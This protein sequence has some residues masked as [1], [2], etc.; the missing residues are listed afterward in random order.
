MAESYSPRQKDWRQALHGIL[1]ALGRRAGNGG[2][3]EDE[4]CTTMATE[5]KIPKDVTHD[6]LDFLVRDELISRER[7]EG[8]IVVGHEYNLLP[9][10][11]VLLAG[12]GDHKYIKFTNGFLSNVSNVRSTGGR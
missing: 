5:L 4:L 3:L 8:L 10:G 12:G 7:V 6:A 1:L 9:A 11:V 2:M